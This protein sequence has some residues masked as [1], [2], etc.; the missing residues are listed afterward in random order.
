[1]AKRRNIL[2]NCPECDKPITVAN[3]QGMF[4]EDL[5]LYNIEYDE[6]EMMKKVMGFTEKFNI[7]II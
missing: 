6:I 4:C 2:V 1:M 3:E 7:K 5:C